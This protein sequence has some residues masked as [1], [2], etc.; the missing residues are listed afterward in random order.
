MEW[1]QRSVALTGQLEV[2][3]EVVTPPPQKQKSRIDDVLEN[4]PEKGREQEQPQPA[5]KKTYRPITPPLTEQQPL[6]EQG[7]QGT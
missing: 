3:D 2:P 5:K 6:T 1:L 4:I 7:R